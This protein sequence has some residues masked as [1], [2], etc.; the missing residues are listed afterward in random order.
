MN[1]VYK[2]LKKNPDNRE[3]I[4]S[5]TS[6]VGIVMNIFIALLKI[7]I[8]LIVHSIAIISEGANNASDAMTSIVT[9]LGAK[10]S[11]KHPDEKH[12]FGYG[13][14]E[15]LTSLVVSILILLTGIELLKGSVE[16]IFKPTQLQVTAV[17]V[18]I[19]IISAIIKLLYGTYA[20]KMSK[21]SNS[22][23]LEAVGLDSRNDCIGSVITLGSALAF[24]FFNISLD[25]YAG[26]ITSLI[27][28]KAGYGVLADTIS[29]LIGRPGKRE[30]AL[31][32]YRKIVATDGVIY[33]VDMMLHNYGPDAWSGSVNVEMD[34]KMTI[35]QAYDILH[36][37]QLEIM[38]QYNVTMVFGIY[39]V[40]NDSTESRQ[41]RRIIGE[42][43][44]DK[45]HIKSFHA[46]YKDEKNKKLYCDF[47]VD[48]Y[49]KD[50][51]KARA[52]FIEYM[53]VKY[54]DYQIILTIETEFV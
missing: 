42:Y 17:S 25:A 6:L 10:L 28:I 37:L 5:V 3:D 13:R 30:L 48:Y 29:E 7:A 1:I 8:G 43:I 9:F 4:I 38:Q 53:S 21:K 31:E 16:M 27:I 51:D 19:I 44:R 12:P 32:L 35:S 46:V 18:G 23:A 33:A 20:L 45:E 14:I 40:D 41:I 47:L 50:W 49:L 52:E 54:P 11:T 36:A 24:V 2:L 34:H 15:Y 26:I 39:S 22:S